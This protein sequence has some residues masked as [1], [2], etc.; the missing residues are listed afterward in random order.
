[1]FESN[2]LKTVVFPVAGQGTR[3]RPA[4]LGTAKELLPVIEKPLLQF[5]I[6]EAAEAGAE[7]L[8][9]VS[10]AKKP[11]IETYVNIPGVT[12][13]CEVVVV[14]QSEALGLGHAVLCAKDYVEHDEFGVI[15]PDDL[16]FG[17]SGCLAQMAAARGPSGEHLIALQGVARQDT[18]KYGVIDPGAIDGPRVSA[19]GIVEKPAPEDAPSQ[20]AVVG[21]YILNTGIFERLAKQTSGTGGE[22]Q[23]TDA[24]AAD[25]ENVGLTGYRFEGT[26]YDCGSPAGMLEATIAYAR[27]R[28]DLASA[29]ESCFRFRDAA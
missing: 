5:A 28:S 6:E 20:L 8:I 7:K 4:T 29:I 17:L 14:N 9:F 23:L 1:M 22:I 10:S 16:I 19:K 11:G 26:R 21:R 2:P 18:S 3:F 12:A 13:D 25:I 27:T 15:L 24:L